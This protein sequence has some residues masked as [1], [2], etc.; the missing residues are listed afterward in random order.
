VP[1]SLYQLGK[2]LDDI[3]EL[4]AD[5]R[6]LQEDKEELSNK[7]TEQEQLAT[8]LEDKLDSLSEELYEK[9][10]STGRSMTTGWNSKGHI[11]NNELDSMRNVKFIDLYKSSKF[12]MSKH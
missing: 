5:N 1:A 3:K 11:R 10:V 2:M 12:R 4:I 7:I 9:I 8:E 6:T